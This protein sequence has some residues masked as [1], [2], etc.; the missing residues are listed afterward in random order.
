[1]SKSLYRRCKRALIN[2]LKVPAQFNTIGKKPWELSIVDTAELWSF[3]AWQ[4]SFTS[5]DT[6]TAVLNIPSP[7]SDIDGSKVSEVFWEEG[8][9][10]R[11]AKYCE[12]DVVATINVLI[13]L[14]G[15][16]IAEPSNITSVE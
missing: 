8:D 16:E 1:M 14:S 15:F 10:D 7:K 2:G 6:L 12:Q 13:A 3:G 11:I 4:E 5:L 9:L